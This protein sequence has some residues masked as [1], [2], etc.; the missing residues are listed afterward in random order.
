[1][2]TILGR[3]TI[4]AGL[5]LF[6]TGPALAQDEEATPARLEDGSGRNIGR[7]E[8]LE[9]PHDYGLYFKLF[10]DNGSRL[11]IVRPAEGA[12][13]DAPAQFTFLEYRVDPRNP[14]ARGEEIGSGVATIDPHQLGRDGF[15]TSFSGSMRLTSKAAGDN[16]VPVSEASQRFKIVLQ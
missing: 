3:I 16:D 15:V 4:A 2:S 13:R 12:R 8:I 6:L 5:V 10:L 14:K 7:A 1:M 11:R 9:S